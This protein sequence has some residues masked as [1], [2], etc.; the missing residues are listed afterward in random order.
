MASDLVCADM[1]SAGEFPHLTNK[2]SVFGVPKTL[3]NEQ[4]QFEGSQPER[5]F[6]EQVM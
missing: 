5:A 1:V 4:V 2:Y 3:I 6:V